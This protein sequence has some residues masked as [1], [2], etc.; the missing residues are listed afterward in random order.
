MSQNDNGH[1]VVPWILGNK[2]GE[3]IPDA[4]LL[5]G[6]VL[7]VSASLWLQ[8][9]DPQSNWFMR[10]GGMVVLLG[11]ILEY[12]HVTFVSLASAK[13][14]E[15]ASGVGGPTVFEL[16][17]LRRTIGYVAHACVV[18]GTFIATYGDLIYTRL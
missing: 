7:V 13:S 14:I 3:A 11:A 5:V 9:V 2:I 17:R 6:V 18:V 15:W 10:S 8:S 12:R 4:I 16:S 1:I